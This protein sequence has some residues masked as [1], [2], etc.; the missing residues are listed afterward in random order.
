MQ[1]RNLC[2]VGLSLTLLTA[3]AASSLQTS[4][5]S[6]PPA[7]EVTLTGVVLDA[8]GA[9]LAGSTVRLSGSM[10]RE[11]RITN[12]VTLDEAVTNEAGVFTLSGDPHGVPAS[13]GG[14]VPME[15]DVIGGPD[16]AII[17]PFV[18][19]PPTDAAGS[20][21]IDI[22]VPASGVPVFQVG[23]G[24]VEESVVAPAT[25]RKVRARAVPTT[26]MTTTTTASESI[27]AAP[28]ETDGSETTV[29]GA[30][31]APSGYII[32]GTGGTEC[33]SGYSVIGWMAVDS[34]KYNEVPT[35]FIKT[36]NNSKAAWTIARSNE[37]KL[38]IAIDVA[39]TATA[40]SALWESA[41]N[42][43]IEW[44]PSVGNNVQSIFY[45]KWRFQK[46]KKI[47]HD[48]LGTGHVWVLNARRWM[49]N[50]PEAGNDIVGTIVSFA[51]G[52]PGPA[53]RDFITAPVALAQGST[54]KL[55]GYFRIAG[56][57]L[58]AQQTD[59]SSQVLKI[60]PDAGR[61]AEWCGSNDS[62]AYAKFVKEVS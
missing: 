41:S 28:G 43:S 35:K 11:N 3:V 10:P 4:T 59:A 18:A 20:W 2:R 23:R 54:S 61:T 56:V 60:T 12:L 42:R 26:T 32:D 50:R 9:P 13:Q 33:P 7:P 31:A 40:G 46:E 49:P 62:P 21:L 52:G 1:K 37:T 25:A 22:P 44:T 24:L 30:E 38:G 51:C 19:T 39:G 15:F 55:G 45:I 57:A 6:A 29:V 34:Y 48:S 14:A 8:S 53:Y 58:D 17:H 27:D 5:A 36:G 47:C 16:E